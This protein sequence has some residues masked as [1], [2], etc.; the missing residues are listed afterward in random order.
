LLEPFSQKYTLVVLL[1]PAIV[2]GRL[3][4]KS[5][6]RGIL[7]TAAVMSFIQPLIYGRNTQ[8]LMQVLGVD[9]LLTALL[10]VFLLV[11]VY[12]SSTERWSSG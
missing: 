9:F 1:W 4:A 10:A 8:R 12:E 2:A 5:Q 6:A 7:W 3:A 11:S